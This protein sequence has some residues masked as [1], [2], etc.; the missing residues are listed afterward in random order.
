MG[1]KQW[2][3]KKGNKKIFASSEDKIWTATALSNS[4]TGFKSTGFIAKGGRNKVYESV[5]IHIEHAKKR[6]NW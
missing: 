2:F 4:G 3:N 6:G 5:R 1:I